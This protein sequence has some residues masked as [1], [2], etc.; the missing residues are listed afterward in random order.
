MNDTSTPKRFSSLRAHIIRQFVLFAILLSVIFGFF[1]LITL[2]NL[3]DEFI[4]R[5]LSQ[6]ADMVRE[7]FEQA[8]VWSQPKASYIKLHHSIE[9]FPNE[10]IATIKEEPERIEIAGDEGRHYH[11]YRYNDNAGPFLVAEVSELL[12]VRPSKKPLFIL[13]LIG[14]SIICLFAAWLGFRLG[15][16]TLAPLTSLAELV[17]DVRP[18]KLPQSFSKDYPRNEI[19]RL[20]LTLDAAMQQIRTFIEREQHFTRDSSHELR[21][22]LAVVKNAAE[23]LQQSADNLTNNQKTLLTR[24]QASCEQMQQTVTT[25]LTLAREDGPSAINQPTKVLPIVEQVIIQQAHLLENKTVDV[26]VTVDTHFHVNMRQPDLHIV[27]MNIIG[28]A[29]QYTMQGQVVVSNDDNR[30]VITDTGTG[31]DPA[32]KG[33]EA[34][35]L[36]KSK[37][38]PGF[39]IGLSLVTRL[40]EKYQI[41]L[42]IDD[43]ANGTRV[44]LDFS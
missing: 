6:E 1:N 3:E 10:I 38:S 43:M 27:L 18:E 31:I 2:Y 25:L 29:F 34:E 17:T 28:N 35:T 44:I 11:I 30:L 19:G 36:V 40:C 32:I 39:G 8:G 15:R 4:N 33:R 5:K 7:R 21:T 12:L 13:L 26:E 14:T 16:R 24:I 41:P 9:T 20:A 23:L 42:T 22:P 37:D